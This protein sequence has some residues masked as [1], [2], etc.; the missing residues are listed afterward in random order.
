MSYQFDYKEWRNVAKLA[1]LAA[2]RE[3]RCMNCMKRLIR[4]DPVTRQPI[5]SWYRCKQWRECKNCYSLRMQEELNLFESAIE[6]YGSLN[7]IRDS[8]DIIKKYIRRLRGKAYRRYPIEGDLE[9]LV[10]PIELRVDGV[11]SLDDFM[12]EHEVTLEQL[13]HYL[14]ETPY[15]KARTG[16]L[17]PKKKKQ[18]QECN[19]VISVCVGNIL[20]DS[21]DEAQV[22][23]LYA[24]VKKETICAVDAN[25]PPSLVQEYVQEAI[26]TFYEN[27]YEELSQA[28]IEYEIIYN[29]KKKVSMPRLATEWNKQYSLW[30]HISSNNTIRYRHD[31]TNTPEWLRDFSKKF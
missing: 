1:E 12:Q 25:A 3:Y 31:M 21:N 13:V 18:E 5:Y 8:S 23:Q 22:S 29:V 6:L 19:N 9:A 11:Q 24:K 16:S 4:F 14:N 10:S 7:I 30:G 20:F 27:L 28:G 2:N 17:L 15:R 26:D